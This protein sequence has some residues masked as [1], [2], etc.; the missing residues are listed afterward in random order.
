MNFSILILQEL[1][2]ANPVDPHG[3]DLRAC[4]SGGQWRSSE[5]AVFFLKLQRIPTAALNGAPGDIVNRSGI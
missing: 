2:F 4:K 5:D 1:R 3:L